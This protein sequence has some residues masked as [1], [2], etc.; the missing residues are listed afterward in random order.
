[1]LDLSA[2]KVLLS[3]FDS[4]SKHLQVL[5]NVKK[6]TEVQAKLKNPEAALDEYKNK[7]AQAYRAL[8]DLKQEIR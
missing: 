4:P 5:E 2:R 7:L 3:D 8:D 6:G 1:M